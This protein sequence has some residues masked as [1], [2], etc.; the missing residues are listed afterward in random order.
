MGFNRIYPLVN[1]YITMENQGKSPCLMGKS[2]ILTVQFSIATLNY[3]RVYEGIWCRISSIPGMKRES[4]Y[5][6]YIN[7]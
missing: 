7:R 1:V 2:T 4:D 6:S 3:Q 5:I